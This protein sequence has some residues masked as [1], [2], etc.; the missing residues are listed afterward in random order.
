M[1]ASVEQQVVPSCVTYSQDIVLYRLVKFTDRLW[2]QYYQ[3]CNWV[4]NTFEFIELD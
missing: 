4:H 3:T 1:N 2:A